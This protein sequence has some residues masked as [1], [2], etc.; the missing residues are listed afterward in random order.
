MKCG[1]Y[2]ILYFYR[3]ARIQFSIVD[4][5]K[6]TQSEMS[7]IQVFERLNASVSEIPALYRVRC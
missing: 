7:Q 6:G 2:V 1:V 4:T 5:I 3:S